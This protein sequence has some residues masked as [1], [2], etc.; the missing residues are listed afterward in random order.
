M[1]DLQLRLRH[2][3]QGEVRPDGG[4]HDESQTLHALR[5]QKVLHLPHLVRLAAVAL[6]GAV[7]RGRGQ[8]AE[9]LVLQVLCHRA[10]ARARDAHG[11]E[12]EDRGVF[13]VSIGLKQHRIA[14]VSVS[15][16]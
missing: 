16:I 2:K 15:R 5:A 9:I 1:P 10:A 11:V 14:S 3:G 4:S 13:A 6:T 12:K 8:D 7:D